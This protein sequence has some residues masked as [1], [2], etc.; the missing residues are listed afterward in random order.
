MN[1]TK[2]LFIL[3]EA[4]RINSFSYSGIIAAKNKGW[5]FHIAG[6]WSYPTKEAREA[7][8]QKYGI[9]IHHVDFIRS[10]YSPENKRAY[11]QLKALVEKEKFDIIHC[12]TPIGGLLGRLVGKKCKVKKVIYQVHGFHFYKGAPLLNKLVYYPIEKL[13]ARSTD[14]GVTVDYIKL[15]FFNKCL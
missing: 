7:D 14:R 3:N 5:D 1:K 10:P 9:K 13:L 2:I 12:N 4:S 15:F 6:K 8:E 11:Q